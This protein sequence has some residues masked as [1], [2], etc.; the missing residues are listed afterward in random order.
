MTTVDQL[1][2]LINGFE[3]Q[4]QDL[5]DLERLRSFYERMKREGVAK[6]RNYEI[7]QVDTIGRAIYR[8][9]GPGHR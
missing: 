2:K 6:T 9:L 3:S 4:S 1:K 7:P 5:E 8:E